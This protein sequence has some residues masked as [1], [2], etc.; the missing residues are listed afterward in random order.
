[1]A[2]GTLR[3]PRAAAAAGCP[4]LCSRQRRLTSTGRSL[5]H[6]AA[7]RRTQHA[8]IEGCGLQLLQ[9][10]PPPC[11]PRSC[12]GSASAGRRRRHAAGSV[13]SELLPIPHVLR[14]R[15]ILRIGARARRDGGLRHT[16]SSNGM[17][18]HLVGSAPAARQHLLPS[19]CWLSLS[20]TA[21]N[22]HVHSPSDKLTD[23]GRR[24]AAALLERGNRA[25]AIWFGSSIWTWTFH[26]WIGLDWIFFSI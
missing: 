11:G 12:H 22:P 23:R 21:S 5:T 2:A 18:R 6:V 3:P 15:S 20:E 25:A 26:R 10:A 17:H 4:E 16:C 9:D 1:M 13:W 19:C 24:R 14:H 8:G 7:C